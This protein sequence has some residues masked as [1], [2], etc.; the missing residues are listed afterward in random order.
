[1]FDRSNLWIHALGI[2]YIEA[3]VT[4]YS[5]CLYAFSRRRLYLAHG[6]FAFSLLFNTLVSS[7]LITK[8][9]L[10]FIAWDR[11]T[12]TFFVV[13][14]GVLLAVS[15]VSLFR[16]FTQSKRYFPAVDGMLKWAAAGSALF[17][18]LSLVHGFPATEAINLVGL[19]LVLAF[20]VL[21]VLAIRKGHRE[22]VYQLLTFAS[23]LGGAIALTIGGLQPRTTPFVIATKYLFFYGSV[24]SLAFLS[25]GVARRMR[26][27]EAERERVTSLF[28]AYVS[29]QVVERV[30]ADSSAWEGE[31]REATI[32]FT[33]I[34]DYT[35][36][37]ET[38]A[39]RDVVAMLNEYFTTLVDIVNRH[40]G[41]VNKF[42]GDSLMALFNVPLDQPDHAGHA[43]AAALAMLDWTERSSFGPGLRFE[44][45]VGVHS[46]RVVAGNVGSMARLEYS[47]LG[48]A[49]NT[50]ARLERMNKEYG[51]SLLVSGDT[52]RLAGHPPT[53]RLVGEDVPIRG[54]NRTCSLWT[55]AGPRPT[56]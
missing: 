45:R 17:L 46:G 15:G 27:L 29:E 33:D 34:R 55:L 14:S 16:D 23:F 2:S 51:T 12:L 42:M 25:I 48:D 19:G 9:A 7:A 20:I 54:K 3:F 1:M 10:P 30:L 8:L 36:L 52:A 38:L 32:V 31:E 6:F 39:P 28:G 43:V 13:L 35:S 22:A 26:A 4:V 37:T 24:L 21:S 5:L 40:G 53:L 18:P 49:V 56:A 41:V 11:P 47:V 50:A 44:T